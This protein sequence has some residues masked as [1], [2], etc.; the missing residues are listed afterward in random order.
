M[1]NPKKIMQHVQSII[2]HMFD[3]W[4]NPLVHLLILNSSMELLLVVIGAA[5]KEKGHD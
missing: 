5:K 2:R 4:A 1:L 3:C